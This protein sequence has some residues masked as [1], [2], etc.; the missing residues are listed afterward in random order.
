MFLQEV[1]LSAQTG[2]TTS[3]TFVTEL[4]CGMHQQAIAEPRRSC[5]LNKCISYS[6][7][8]MCLDYP[9]RELPPSFRI[10]L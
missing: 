4:F 9:R 3:S 6:W 2:A 1:V 8:A 5:S 10:P 7:G